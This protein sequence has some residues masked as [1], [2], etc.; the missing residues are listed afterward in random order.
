MK[1]LHLPAAVLVASLLALASTAPAQ[2]SYKPR[3]FPEFRGAWTLDEKATEDLQQ[4]TTRTG[5]SRV[6]DVLGF[7]VARNLVIA[8]S[9]TEFTVTKDS[10]L[11][12]VYRFD[13]S[14]NQVRD[15]RTNAPLVPTYRFTLVSG[16]LALT[17]KTPRGGTTE[18]ITDLYSMPEWTVLKVERQL[19]I[20]APEGHLMTL[21]RERNVPKTLVYRREKETAKPPAGR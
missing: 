7:Q 8:T 6:Y 10:G 21:A 15:P 20:L 2:D 13:G 14:E 4:T 18:V 3:E 17:T 11:V 19:S 16:Q 5:E 12:E 1:R 9:P